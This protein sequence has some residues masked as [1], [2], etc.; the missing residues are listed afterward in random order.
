MSE[1]NQHYY[2]PENSQW[3]IIGAVALFTL[4]FGFAFWVNGVS[5]GPFISAVGLGLLGFLFFGW[6]QVLLAKVF[7]INITARLMRHLDKE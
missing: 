6:F 4:F 7:L 2:V 5:V 3:P 1:S